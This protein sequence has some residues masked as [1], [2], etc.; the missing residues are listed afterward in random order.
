MGGMD[1]E[2]KNKLAT[3]LFPIPGNIR[4]YLEKI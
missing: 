3:T 1:L 2:R 4:E